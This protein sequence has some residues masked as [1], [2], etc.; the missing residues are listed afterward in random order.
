MGGGRRPRNYSLVDSA[1]LLSREWAYQERLL[2]PRIINFHST[3]P[4]WDCGWCFNCECG[5]LLDEVDI[6]LDGTA[7]LR[8]D[9]FLPSVDQSDKET[10]MSS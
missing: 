9:A 5:H 6:H 7:V 4:T 10:I 8:K 3:E 2:S 1:P